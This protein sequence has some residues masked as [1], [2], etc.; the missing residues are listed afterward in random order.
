MFS[1]LM[2]VYAKENPS[3]LN[4]ALQSLVDQTIQAAQ[5]VLV[6]DGPLGADLNAVIASFHGRLRITSVLL[7]HNVGL[8]EA[9][10]AGI[11]QCTQPWIMRFDSD[12]ICVPDRIARQM[13]VAVSDEVD[14]FGGQI[15]EFEND[16]DEIHG[17]RIVPLSHD[18]IVATLPRRCPFNHM[19][20]CYRRDLVQDGYPTIRY[21]EDYAMWA[22]LIAR[23]LRTM[24]LPETL[25]LARAGRALMGRRSSLPYIRAQ[26]QLQRYM[27]S[28]GL[29]SNLASFI[30]AIWRCAFFAAPS[31]LKQFIYKNFLRTGKT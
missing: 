7:P 30:D 22:L 24:N 26:W 14:L 3:N 15:D 2:A 31:G 23:G 20:I 4:D 5:V 16:T 9:L 12:D 8:A 18:A 1:V 29:K 28:L 11:P 17:R 13:A 6:E 19:T 10:N 25:V 21:I 27:Y